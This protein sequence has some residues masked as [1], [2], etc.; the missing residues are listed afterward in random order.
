MSDQTNSDVVR[1][2]IRNGLASRVAYHVFDAN[3]A[4]SPA[5]ET[6]ADPRA[7]VEHAMAM[8]GGFEHED[9]EDYE[10]I[11]QDGLAQLRK[12]GKTYAF[13]GPG[14]RWSVRA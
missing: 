8:A 6:F 3:S 14:G 1:E 11:V 13:R 10:D 5:L 4:E 9:A 7:A 12:T 2:G